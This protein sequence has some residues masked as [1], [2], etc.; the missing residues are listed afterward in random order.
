MEWQKSISPYILFMLKTTLMYCNVIYLLLNVHNNACQY[1]KNICTLAASDTVALKIK[2]ETTEILVFD[3]TRKSL[4]SFV[5][6][7]YT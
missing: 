6:T 2:E 7:L 5:W 3:K 1:K 4:K